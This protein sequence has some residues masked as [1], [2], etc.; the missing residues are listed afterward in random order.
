MCLGWT[1]KHPIQCICR[2]AGMLKALEQYALSAADMVSAWTLEPGGLG[3]GDVKKLFC[4][5]QNDILFV[6]LWDK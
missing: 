6:D 4:R 5:C 2:C 3:L 1:H